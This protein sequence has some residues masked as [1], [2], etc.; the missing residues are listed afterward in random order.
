MRWNVKMKRVI[1]LQGMTG[2][3]RAQ[4]GMQ[5]SLASQTF[6]FASLCT[7]CI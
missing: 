7:P 2:T 1:H 5:G 3:A 6:M 4:L